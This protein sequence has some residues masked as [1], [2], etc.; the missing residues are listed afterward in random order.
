MK[1]STQEHLLAKRRHPG[2]PRSEGLSTADEEGRDDESHLDAIVACPLLDHGP[3]GIGALYVR[4]GPRARLEPL[5]HGGGHEWGMRSG[6]LAT[7]QVV[8]MGA[9]APGGSF[10][11]ESVECAVPVAVAAALLSAREDVALPPETVIFGEIS[12]SGALRPVGQAENRLKEAQKLGFS[13]ALLPAGSKAGDGSGLRLMKQ[14][15]LAGFVGDV[16]G[17]G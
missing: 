15:D 1:G 4:R 6:T 8:G 13:S 7:H 12:L 11:F 16:F 3:K 17:A 9:A 5:I 14:R 2:C 10:A